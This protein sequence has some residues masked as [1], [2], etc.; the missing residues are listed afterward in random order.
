MVSS[1]LGKTWIEHPTSNNALIEPTCM[2]SLIKEEFLIDGKLQKVVLFSNPNSKFKREKMTIKIS[3][4]DG[5]TWPSEY[6]LLLDE[7][8]GRGYSCLTKIDDRNLGI[9]Y[10]SSQADLVFQI[11]PIEEIIRQ[12]TGL[13][14]I[15]TSGTEGYSTFR[16]PAIL[17]TNSGKIIA[18][19]EGRVTSSSDTGDIDSHR[20]WLRPAI[21][22]VREMIRRST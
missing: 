11:V 4:D 17:T 8:V 3:F 21:R 5:K 10:E 14:N 15:F 13:N 9:L 1:D 7:L 20:G 16:I 12:H 22:I 2:A 6:H 18:F 19:A